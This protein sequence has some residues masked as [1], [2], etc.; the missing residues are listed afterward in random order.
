VGD[1]ASASGECHDDVPPARELSGVVLYIED[2]LVNVS[3]VETLLARHPGIRLMSVMKAHLGLE[4][5]E[6]HQPDVILLDS[7]LPD[8]TGEEAL[9]QLRARR[10]THDIPVIVISADADPATEHRLLARGA[11]AY[12]TKPFK[13]D[14]LL[15]TIADAMAAGAPALPP[16]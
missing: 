5:A 16:D 1:P 6:Q 7:N 9:A 13:V 8:L 3:L 14:E 12:L 11:Y 10:A 15:D 2:N 4:L